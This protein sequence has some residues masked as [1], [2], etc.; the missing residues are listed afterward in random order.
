MGK[1]CESKSSQDLL[2]DKRA[3]VSADSAGGVRLHNRCDFPNPFDR[4]SSRTRVGVDNDE[5]GVLR[6]GGCIAR[7]DPTESGMARY[8]IQELVRTIRKSPVRAA[9]AALILL[10]ATVYICTDHSRIPVAEIGEETTPS[11]ELTVEDLASEGFIEQ[12]SVDESDTPAKRVQSGPRDRYIDSQVVPAIAELSDDDH[13][14]RTRVQP[15]SGQVSRPS[16]PQKPVW[17]LGI[18]I[19]E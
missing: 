9:A 13:A 8:I 12:V 18:L 2:A 11:I 19:D 15:V 14:H 17:L 5:D 4:H 1:V 7:M 16:P 3:G 10:G 6:Q